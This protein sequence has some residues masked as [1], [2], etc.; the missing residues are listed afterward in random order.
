MGYD[1]HIQQTGKTV[2]DW[3]RFLATEPE[4]E[5][6]HEIVAANPVTGDVIRYEA[7]NSGRAGNGALFV[8]RDRDGEVEITVSSPDDATIALMKHVA[9]AFGGRVFGDE[10]EEY[11]ASA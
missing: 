7:P 8:P 2:H 4:L 1:L 9:A 5:L 10:G 11:P 6:V 3:V